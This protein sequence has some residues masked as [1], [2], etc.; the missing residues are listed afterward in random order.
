[1]AA[2]PKAKDRETPRRR[3]RLDHRRRGFLLDGKLQKGFADCEDLVDA[4]RLLVARWAQRFTPERV[5][6]AQHALLE[7]AGERSASP[8][9]RELLENQREL[10]L[11]YI[12]ALYEALTEEQ[13]RIVEE[14]G[15]SPRVKGADYP[16]SVGDLARLSEVS[17]RQVRK[18]AD[19]GLLPSYRDGNH[20]RFYS[21][22]LIRAFVIAQASTQEKAV[23]SAAAHGRAGHLFQ[24]IAATMGRA[25]ACFPQEQSTRLAALSQELT[26]SSRLMC[27]VDSRAEVV[28][29]WDEVPCTKRDLQRS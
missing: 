7:G 4:D 9:Q 12:E 17:E 1:M 13:R 14:P 24:L 23:L 21:A 22:A 2:K 15:S 8:A 16:L 6:E 29:M 27:D 20:R 5:S 25:A 19:D 10:R 26:W 3:V 11:S 28:R 18:W